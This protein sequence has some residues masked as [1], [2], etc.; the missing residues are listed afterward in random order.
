MIDRRYTLR[1]LG[2]GRADSLLFDSGADGS[3]SMLESEYAGQWTGL[4]QQYLQQGS[5]IPAFLSALTLQL[6]RQAQG[7]RLDG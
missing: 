2:A 4:I 3:L 6:F 7:A 5:S 1:P